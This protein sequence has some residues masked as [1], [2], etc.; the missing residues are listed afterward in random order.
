MKLPSHSCLE[1]RPYK[2]AISKAIGENM[3]DHDMPAYV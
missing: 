2:S 3:S 1:K